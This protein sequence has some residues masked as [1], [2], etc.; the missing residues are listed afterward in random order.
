MMMIMM[1]T[2]MMTKRAKNSVYWEVRYL[3]GVFSRLDILISVSVY[4]LREHHFDLRPVQH[5]TWIKS[6][7]KFNVV[8]IYDSF[9][10]SK[11]KQQRQTIATIAKIIGA[12]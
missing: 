12:N 1:M 10:T 8:S 3:R 9:Q 7:G 11:E 5:A 2:M 6:S 4:G